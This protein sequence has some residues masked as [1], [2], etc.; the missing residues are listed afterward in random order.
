M[1][2]KTLT[3]LLPAEVLDKVDEHA[4]SLCLSRSAAVRLILLEE[5]KRRSNEILNALPEVAA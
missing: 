1:P 3:V 4:R 5:M 2:T